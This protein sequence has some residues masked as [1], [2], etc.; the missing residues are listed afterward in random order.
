MCLTRVGETYTVLQK[1]KDKKLNASVGVRLVDALFEDHCVSVVQAG[2]VTRLPSTR[3]VCVCMFVCTHKQNKIAKVI[4][5]AC[6]RG[7]IWWFE[8]EWP[9]QAP[10]FKCLVCLDYKD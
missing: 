6:F 4:T 10:I 8:K 5:L 9:P 7:R 2:E 3:C 1:W